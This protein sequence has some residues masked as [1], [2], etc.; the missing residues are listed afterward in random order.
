MEHATG[1]ETTTSPY[2]VGVTV[3]RLTDLITRQGL[4]LFGIVDHSG[5][6]RDVGLEM[7]D[8]KLVI[9]GNPRAGTPV[10]L[11]KPLSALDLPLKVLVRAADAD[12]CLVSYVTS[13]A[14]AERYG[15]PADLVAPLGRV[16]AL[17][18]KA[19][20]RASAGVDD[21]EGFS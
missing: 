20:S 8:T 2:S 18:E 6:A 3:E 1:V 17:V 16:A 21:A 14:I 19:V 11:A 7:P 15:V 12:G 13:S 5:G 9:F 4:L 10:M